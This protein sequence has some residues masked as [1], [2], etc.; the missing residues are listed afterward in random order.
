[1]VNTINV[2]N[3]NTQILLAE[4]KGTGMKVEKISYV[5]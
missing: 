3:L 2:D 5:L 1:M 4:E